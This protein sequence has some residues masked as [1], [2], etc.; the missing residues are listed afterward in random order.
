MEWVIGRRGCVTSYT[1]SNELADGFPG[2][3]GNSALARNIA[4]S[5]NS[6]FVTCPHGSNVGF[7]GVGHLVVGGK[8][9]LAGFPSFF[10]NKALF[11]GSWLGVGIVFVF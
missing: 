2:I 11:G 3:V 5:D 9:L 4:D 6:F 7:H 8:V 1:A 10:V